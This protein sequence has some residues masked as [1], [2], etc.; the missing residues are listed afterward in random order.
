MDLRQVNRKVLESLVKAGAFDALGPK[1][2]PVQWRARL[3]ASLDNA[4]A[5][6]AKIREEVEMGQSSLF[7]WSDMTAPP[8]PNGGNGSGD[9]AGKAG[10]RLSLA[11]AAAWSEHQLLAGEKEVLGFY[12]SGHPLARFQSELNLFST[13]RLDQLPS[14]NSGVRLAGLLSS[15]RRMVTKAKKEPYAR[16]RFEDMEGEVDLVIFPKAYANGI[17]QLL[18]PN[19]MMVVTGK[20]NRREEGGPAEILVD[21]MVPLAKA[22]ERFVS[23]MQVRMTSAGLDE[24]LLED[25]KGILSRYP[26]RCRVCFQVE[27]APGS[28]V[29]IETDFSVKPVPELFEAI[30]ARLGHECW[31]ITKVGR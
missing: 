25:V 1:E 23:E 30:E 19:E 28:A 29:L 15:V 20:V 17:S 11:D 14:T 21:E 10:G 31:T 2:K 16:C 18:K 26:G 27:T 22:R 13:H 5:R 8:P 7:A 4:M 6:A 3:S 9:G 12:L 24:G